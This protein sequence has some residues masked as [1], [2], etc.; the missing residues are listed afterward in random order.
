MQSKSDQYWTFDI[1]G[2]VRG[3]IVAAGVADLLRVF[4]LFIAIRW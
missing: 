1:T 3:I 4:V 2:E